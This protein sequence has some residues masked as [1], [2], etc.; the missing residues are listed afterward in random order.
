M[1]VQ[2]PAWMTM[3]LNPR[4]CGTTVAIDGKDKWLIHNHLASSETDFESVD[5]DWALRTI[6]GV[7]DRFRYEVLSKEDWIGRRLVADRFRDRRAFICGDAAH[8][9]IPY[10]GYGMNAGI[11]DAVDLCWILAAVLQGWA[12][13]AMLDAYEA[14]RQPITEQVSQYAMNHALAVM[15]QRRSVPAEI[16]ADGAA[17][18]EAREKVGRAAYDLNVQQYCCAG[19]NFGYYYDR[20]PIIAHD[21]ETPP[22]YSMGSFTASTVPGARVPHAWLPDGRSLLDGLGPAYTLVRFDTSIDV[23]ALTGAAA[24]S[25]VPLAVL[26]VD[27]NRATPRAPESLLIVRPDT[28]IAWRGDAVPQEP[29]RLFDRLRGAAVEASSQRRVATGEVADT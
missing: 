27:R 5:R 11:A 6:L 3:S 22:P 21:S 24:Q 18:D 20:S 8:L 26:D 10:A 23:A 28:H 16:E 4:R 25:G 9:W 15:S 29:L 7:D 2:K 14:E 12:S 1:I 19:L 17:G 13:P